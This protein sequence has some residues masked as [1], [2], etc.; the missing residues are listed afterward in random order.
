MWNSVWSSFWRRRGWMEEDLHSA[1]QGECLMCGKT[2]INHPFG[3]GLYHLF[4]VIWGWFII[5]LPTWFKLFLGGSI[6]K[7]IPWP[8][9]HFPSFPFISL[10]FP[11]FPFI[12]L[13]F[14]SFPFISLHF[15]AVPVHP[16]RSIPVQSNSLP[17]HSFVI[18][19]PYTSEK[20]GKHRY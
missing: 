7:S 20:T 11:S 9:L 1:W 4:M 16:V 6:W 18:I 12:S 19:C 5:V 2:I 13:H 8:S 3:N 14:P 15:P 17:F 10:H